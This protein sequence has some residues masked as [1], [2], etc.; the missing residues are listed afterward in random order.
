MPRHILQNVTWRQVRLWYNGGMREQ[1]FANVCK[2]LA[3][4]ERW[5]VLR[6]VVVSADGF[7]STVSDISGNTH[8]GVSATSQYLAQL[9]SECGLARARR[10]GRY[11]NYLFEVNRDFPWAGELGAALRKHFRGGDGREVAILPALANTARLQVGAAVRRSGRGTKL[12]LQKAS[13]MSEINVRRHL[14][15]IVGSGL[16]SEDGET[17]VFEEPNDALG[18]LFLELALR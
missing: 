6:Q 9:E 3:N 13:K 7:G 15:V 10:E 1:N 16:A 14:A 17:F 8:L 12:D 18:G 11:V 5:A 2:R 4:P